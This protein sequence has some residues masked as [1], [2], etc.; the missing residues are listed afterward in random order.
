MTPQAR[1]TQIPDHG[2]IRGSSF[3]PPSI[4]TA[5]LGTVQDM[6]IASI[7]PG[8]IRGNHYHLER[9]E[10][11]LV[12]Y[13]D[14][15][16]FYWDAGPETEARRH[17]FAGGGLVMIEVE[18]GASHAIRNEGA[19]TLLMIGMSSLSFDPEHPDSYLR[20]VVPQ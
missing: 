19:Q 11:L 15:W 12:Q 4:W 5:F 6:H 16:S 14:R 9:R 1:I 20:T 8:A 13:Q 18:P 17:S 7:L 2:D 10:I 3:T